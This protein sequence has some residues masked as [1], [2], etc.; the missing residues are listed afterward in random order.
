MQ[1][2]DAQMGDEAM[3]NAPQPDEPE[4]IGIGSARALLGALNH[5]Q[6]RF[7]DAGRILVFCGWLVVTYSFGNPDANTEHFLVGFAL[8]LLGVCL[9]VLSPVVNQFPGAAQVCAWTIS[10]RWRI[11]FWEVR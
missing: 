1:V 5:L 6:H 9:L 2:L 3:A 4:V 11:S 8:L 10:S 7:L